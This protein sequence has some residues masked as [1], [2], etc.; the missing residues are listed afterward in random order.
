MFCAT[1]VSHEKD[2][3]PSRTARATGRTRDSRRRRLP[4]AGRQVHQHLLPVRLPQPEHEGGVQERQ[5]LDISGAHAGHLRGPGG[6]AGTP[7]EVRQVA[8]FPGRVARC[9]SNLKFV[10]RQKL[11]FELKCMQQ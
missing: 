4:A 10:S 8:G 7:P 5:R 3:G 6:V 2:V 9:L 11:L 1:G